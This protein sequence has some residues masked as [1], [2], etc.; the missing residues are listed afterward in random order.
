[1]ARKTSKDYSKKYNSLI[2]QLTVLELR[3]KARAHEL[4]KLHPTAPIG[5]G[6]I[7]RE[8]EK[9]P[10]AI[11]SRDYLDIIKRIEQYNEKQS[12]HVQ[13]TMFPKS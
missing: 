8:I 13:T 7:G 11:S 3:I 6:A 1:M 10:I 4:C 2:Q 9:F 12:G 5:M